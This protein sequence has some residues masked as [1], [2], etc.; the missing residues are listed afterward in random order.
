MKSLRSLLI[1]PLAMALA[2]ITQATAHSKSTPSA[3]S[4]ASNETVSLKV[5]KVFYAKKH[6]ATFRAYLVKWED[7][8]V[9]ASDTLVET[10]YHVGDL[11]GIMVIRS[12]HPEGNDRLGLLSFMVLP[13]KAYEFWKQMNH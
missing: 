7:Q 8:E 3:A 1:L 6:N 5:L 13:P 11:A 9:I 12:A 10:D 2:G 4:A